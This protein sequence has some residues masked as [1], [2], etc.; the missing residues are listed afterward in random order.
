MTSLPMRVVSRLIVVTLLVTGTI[1]ARAEPLAQPGDMQ[2]RHDINLLVDEGMINVPVAAWPIPWADIRDQLTRLTS[3]PDSDLIIAAL[4]RL[5]D[6]SRWELDSGEYNFTAWASA[7]AEPR[8]IRTFEDTPREDVEAGLALSW[9]GT[10]FTI[11]LSGTYVDDPVDKDEFRP[12][13][14]YVGVL[15]GNWMVT[16]GWQQ[17]WWGPGNDGTL[18]LTSNARPRPGVSLQRNLSTPFETRWLSW[19]GPWSLTTFMEQLD[20]ERVV[21]DALL[22]GFRFSFRP[23]K[24]LE[25]GLSRTAQWCGD[26]R[27]CD[28]GTFVDVLMGNDNKGINVDPDDEPGNQLGGIDMRWSLPK[29]IPVALYM[30]WI[31]EDAC[32]GSCSGRFVT[33]FSRQLGIEY[34]GTIAGLSHRTHFEWSEITCAKGGFGGSERIPDCAYNHHIYQTGYRYKGRSLAHGTDGDGQSYSFGSTLVD[35]AGHSWN[36]VLRYMEINREGEPDPRHTLSAT[37][38]DRIDFQFSHDRTTDFGRFYVGIGFD[39]L[40]DKASGTDS[41]DMTAFIRWSNR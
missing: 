41:S 3:V 1:A 36:V 27:P 13:D 19:L 5:R 32:T 20:D 8:V 37:P 30:Q 34:W 35:S 26:D 14:T 15:A 18:I 11:N 24:S 39:Y 9:T 12:D 4:H 23:L 2:L 22:W 31:G 38:Q 29:K 16:A 10:R 28:L 40:D 6:R 33:S 17:R 7:A 25:I 21:K